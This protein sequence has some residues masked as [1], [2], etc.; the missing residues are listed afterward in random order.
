VLEKA[1]RQKEQDEAAAK[2][3][4]GKAEKEKRRKHH[5]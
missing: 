2:A 5:G 4:V 3:L 1:Q